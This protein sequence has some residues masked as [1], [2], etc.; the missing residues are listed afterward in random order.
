ME[1]FSDLK[2][3]KGLI[4]SLQIMNEKIVKFRSIQF[5]LLYERMP[6]TFLTRCG[7]FVSYLRD[8]E[9]YFELKEANLDGLMM[10]M[11]ALK[12]FEDAREL[13]DFESEIIEELYGKL[14]HLISEL[15]SSIC[16][17]SQFG[18]G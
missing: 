5:E 1:L 16:P 18:L 8:M 15:W 3:S 6:A 7:N 13:Y 10:I 4:T 2:Q 9:D 17:V 14:I 11:V 12:N